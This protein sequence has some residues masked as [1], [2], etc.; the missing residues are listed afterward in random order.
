VQGGTPLHVLHELGGWRTYD[1]VLRYAHFSADHPAIYARN[2][3]I[4][5]RRPIAMGSV[6]A[7]TAVRDTKS[8]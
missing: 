4:L 6:A 8:N 7:D 5:V 3:D 1:M 2:L